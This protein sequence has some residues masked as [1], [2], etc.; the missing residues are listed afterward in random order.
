MIDYD[1][2]NTIGVV[3]LLAFSIIYQDI[4]NDIAK[5][6]S[7]VRVIYVKRLVHFIKRVVVTTIKS[8]LIE[9]YLI[10]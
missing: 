6:K 10:S 9:F 4:T 5:A 3:L 1:T 8:N 2:A 7:L